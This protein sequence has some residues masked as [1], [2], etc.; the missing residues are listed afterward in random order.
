MF[1]KYSEFINES[2]NISTIIKS[3]KLYKIYDYSINEDGSIDVAN[4][5]DLG[6]HEL[7]HIPINFNWVDGHFWVDQNKLTD[8]SGCPKYVGGDF[9]CS[10]NKLTSL[11]GCPS[12]IKG[13][14]IFTSNQIT[15][16]EGG[17]KTIN[18]KIA[19]K[20]NDLRS[21][22]GFPEIR[23]NDI[24]ILIDGNPVSEILYWFGN[25]VSSIEHIN[26]WDVIDPDEMTV[27]YLRMCEA[28]EDANMWSITRERLMFKRYK[29]ID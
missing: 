10:E 3:C 21:F 11:S 28:L 25:K 9:R 23:K 22:R 24:K 8:L 17:P 26:E 29:L 5:V 4:D 14:L 2:K 1:K 16:F 20:F 27:S 18:G 12:E 7:T 13:D 15:S 6:G 19:C